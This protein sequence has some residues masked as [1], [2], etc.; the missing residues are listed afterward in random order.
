[1][2]ESSTSLRF[3]RASFVAAIPLLLL[4]GLDC[5]W[6]IFSSRS[7]TPADDLDD[8][9]LRGAYLFFLFGWPIIYALL[10]ISIYFATQILSIMGWLSR[11][12]VMRSGLLGIVVLTLAFAMTVRGL[13]ASQRIVEFLSTCL[14][15]AVAFAWAT[16]LWFRIAL[17]PRLQQV[18]VGPAH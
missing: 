17:A 16:S 13:T 2:T 10:G 3:A 6:I 1:M 5:L 18:W 12:C 11:T 8:G 9:A 7:H 14:S 4:L 15:T